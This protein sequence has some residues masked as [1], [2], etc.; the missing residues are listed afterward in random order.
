MKPS[1]HTES[2]IFS[3]DTYVVGLTV[4]GA[5]HNGVTLGLHDVAEATETGL[6]TEE[7]LE[8]SQDTWKN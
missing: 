1:N 2:Q 4:S 8:V 3:I 6:T 5:Q 7:M